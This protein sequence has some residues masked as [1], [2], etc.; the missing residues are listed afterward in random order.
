M[1]D[2]KRLQILV[3]AARG[4]SFA[5][6]AEALSF[7]PSAISQQIS[8]LEAEAG[9]VLFERGPR[10]VR[11]TDAGRALTAH[12][13]AVLAQLA[14]ARAELDAIAGIR[15]GQLRFASFSSATSAF[16]AG[17]AEVFRRR[18]PEIELHF[19]DGEPYESVGRLKSRDVDL[20]VVFSVDD[21]DA[22]LDYDGERVGTEEELDCV[23]LFED[24]YQLVV[25]PHHRLASATSVP[26][27][28]LA[29]ETIVGGSPW[30]A[31]LQRRCAT[32][33]VEVHFDTSYR[34]TGFEAFQAFV[35][36]GR[37]LTLM[38]GLSLGWLREG[39]LAR[40]LEEGPVRSVKLATLAQAYASPA[41]L[42]MIEVVREELGRREGLGQA[43]LAEGDVSSA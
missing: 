4:G 36:A 17:A 23:D 18:Y 16:A 24:P 22:G 6:A 38:P 19:A 26:L 11:L 33:G 7:T 43:P 2:V 31:G 34:A 21:R 27:T 3:V 9:T 28:R 41:V 37:G 14:D 15:A 42:A 40:P 10:G 32:A 35:A 13:E 20:A 29:G 39:L 8:T 25:P 12:A 1:F 30:Y 5:A